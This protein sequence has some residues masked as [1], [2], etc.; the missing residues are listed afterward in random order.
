MIIQ[1]PTDIITFTHKAVIY[2]LKDI[3]NNNYYE[4]EKLYWS[5]PIFYGSMFAVL[6]DNQ[7]EIKIKI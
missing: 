3:V 1:T 7:Y 6:L 5:L 4:L 2:H